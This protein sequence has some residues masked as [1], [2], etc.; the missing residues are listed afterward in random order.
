MAD[1]LLSAASHQLGSSPELYVRPES[2]RPRLDEV[3]SDA[4]IPIVDACAYYEFLQ[5]VN[6]GVRMESM[7]GTR[8]TM[9][10]AQEFFRLPAEQE[11]KYYSDDP[12]K[13]IRFSTSLNSRKETVQNWRD[14]LRLHCY[15]LQD[16]TPKQPSSYSSFK[17]MVRVYGKEVRG[18]GFRTLKLQAELQLPTAHAL[19]LDLEKAAEDRAV[20]NSSGGGWGLGCGGDGEGR[21]GR[22]RGPTAVAEEARVSNTSNLKTIGELAMPLA[23][24]IGLYSIHGDEQLR[25]RH[26]SLYFPLLISLG[27]GAYASLYSVFYHVVKTTAGEGRAARGGGGGGEEEEERELVKLKWLKVALI[28]TGLGLSYR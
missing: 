14:Y 20:S 9:E 17:E 19:T 11:A 7:W 24:C 12:T 13:K 3:I 21:A 1:L 4:T 23:A 25:H 16:F 8:G 2:Q 15:P 6:H 28:C 22:G 26:P 10:V 18:L 27:F 5:A